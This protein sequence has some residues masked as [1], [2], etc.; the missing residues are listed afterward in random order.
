[1]AWREVKLGDT[2]WSV[3][4]VAER[5]A[6]QAAWRLVLA[7]RPT[8]PARRSVY[9]PTPFESSSRSALFAEADRIPAD[10]LAAYLA[11]RVK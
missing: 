5:G 3:S 10:R 1:M 7:F 11:E 9:A 2:Q 4:P 6:H 8:T